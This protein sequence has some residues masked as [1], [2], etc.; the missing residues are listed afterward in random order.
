[1]SEQSLDS[2]IE[3]KNAEIGLLPIDWSV[4]TVENTCEILDSKRVPITKAK[5]ES[6]TIPYYGATGLLDYVRNYI[7]DEELVLVG[8]DGA[9]WSPFA[10]TSYIING[11]TWV[12]NHAH[13]LRCTKVNSVFLK[14][15][16]N[17]SDLRTYINGTTR[18]KLNQAN[19]RIIKIPFPPLPEQQKIASILSKVDEQISLTEAIIEKTEELKNGLI[20][21][22]LTKGIEHTEFKETEIGEIPADWDVKQLG[23]IVKC[24][25][26]G[27]SVNSEKRAVKEDEFAIL[28]TGC[29][30]NGCFRPYENKAITSEIELSRA[31]TIPQKNCIII[32][33]MNT[34]D[35]VGQSG[36]V[37][38]DY[39]SLFLPDR[40][41]Q[42]TFYDDMQVSVKFI[43]YILISTAIKQIISNSATGTSGSM[44]N[45]SKKFVLGMKIPFP[46][47]PEQQKIASILS[48]VDSQIE[49]NKN[50]LYGLEELKKGLMQDLLAGKVRVKVE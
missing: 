1:M 50:Y 45:I 4:S 2:E 23:D 37:D 35:L 43:S 14:N 22:L 3:Y 41:W 17:L 24:L 38:K 44:K 42:A 40:L 18:G 5:R 16:L 46:P 8:E 12:N 13:V 26:S 34:P 10:E 49:Q 31:K 11:K 25:D 32:S 33:R 39:P 30:F 7:F 36:Y 20:Q 47:L 27:V 15:Y 28:K 48:K 29:V 19:L 6:G 9:D 21:Q